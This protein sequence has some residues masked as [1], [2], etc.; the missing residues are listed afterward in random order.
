M[1]EINPNSGRSVAQL[2]E[3]TRN[4]QNKLQ[5]ESVE[6]DSDEALKP[7]PHSRYLSVPSDHMPRSISVE[8]EGEQS[9]SSSG[10]STSK[11]S[12]CELLGMSDKGS[13]CQFR[14]STLP[15]A[16]SLE[17]L[18]IRRNASRMHI[19]VREQV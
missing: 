3:Y 12:A 6:D 11:N 19:S 9:S 13:E 10:S 8:D 14:M 16:D 17:F 1:V 18:P 5:I 7:N 4:D 15:T 2:N